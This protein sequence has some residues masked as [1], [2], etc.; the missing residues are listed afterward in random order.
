VK[1]GYVV[2]R[3]P[4]YSETFIVNEIL[5]HEAAGVELEIFSVLPPED[6]HFQDVIPRVRAPVTYLPSK[7]L[8]VAEFW[9]VLEQAGETFPIHPRQPDPAP[10]RPPER[11]HLN[12]R[13]E[14]QGLQ[15]QVFAA[16]DRHSPPRIGSFRG[17]HSG[18][19]RRQ[20]GQRPRLHNG[21]RGSVRDR[22]RL[23]GRHSLWRTAPEN[24]HRP[25]R[26]TERPYPDPGR[27]DDRPRR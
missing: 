11:D 18:D 19:Q 10:L 13:G 17:D 1:I 26:R 27:A 25:G 24:R 23:A 20:R 5:A 8:K 14:R 7:G 21:A 4:R 9:S 12:R 3:Y 22:H 2:K 16:S 15:A 6:G